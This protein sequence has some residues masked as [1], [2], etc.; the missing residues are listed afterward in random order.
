MI[1]KFAGYES[2]LK[3]QISRLTSQIRA[4]EADLIT[5]KEG[6]LKVQGA[7]ELL[8]VLAKD[9]EETEEEPGTDKM[10]DEKAIATAVQV[11]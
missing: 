4:A 5:L 10:T 11:I 9:F 7:L 2:S 8:D 3:E 6:Y 1:S